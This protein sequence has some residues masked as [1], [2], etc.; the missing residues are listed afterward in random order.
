LR[1]VKRDIKALKDQ[2][3][4]VPIRGDIIGTGRG[5]SH[6]AKIAE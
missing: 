4:F 1:T 2:E 5:E 6:K 3:I